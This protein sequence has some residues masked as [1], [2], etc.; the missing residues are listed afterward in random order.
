VKVT[1]LPLH[2]NV[3][4][5]AN[6]TVTYTPILN[7]IGADSFAYTVSNTAVPP[8]ASNVAT[9]NT[10]VEGGAEVLSIAKA[11]FVASRNQWT[12]VGSTSW[13]GPTLTHTT[14][15]CWNGKG[16]A[17]GALLGT[18][19]VDTT[20]KFALVPPPLTTPAPDATHIFTCQTSNGGS[21]SAAVTVQ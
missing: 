13:F 10:I 8:V 19:P 16:I 9:V 7:Y 3:V 4:V 18:T 20:G 5:N 21:I 6:G 15:T 2:G 1:T 11:T 14:V 12:I 17:V